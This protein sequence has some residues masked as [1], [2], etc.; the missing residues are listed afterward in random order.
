MLT[1]KVTNRTKQKLRVKTMLNR[2]SKSRSAVLELVIA[3]VLVVGAAGTAYTLQH[4][5][6]R[7]QAALTAAQMPY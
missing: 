6:E 2:E 5:P 3:A 1:I 4:T 7:T